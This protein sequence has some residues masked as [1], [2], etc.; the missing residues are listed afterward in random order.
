MTDQNQSASAGHT[1]ALI[2]EEVRSAPSL[3]VPETGR[4]EIVP[5]SLS[6]LEEH[7]ADFAGFQ[8]G[9][10]RDYISLADTKAAW[11]FTIASGVLVYLIGT[12]KIKDALLAPVLSWPYASLIVSVLLLVISAF[13]SFRVVAPRLASKSGEGIVFFGSV[14]AKDDAANYVSEVAAHDPAAITEAR[15][16][17]CFDVSKVCDGKYAS[18]KKA[19][20]FGLPALAVTLVAIVLNT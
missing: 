13:F 10:V 12:E 17:H 16:K 18:L 19:I 9:Y 3:A 4:G 11:T 6:P 5:S 8:E 2:V 20:W 7:H 14:A 1:P 15:L